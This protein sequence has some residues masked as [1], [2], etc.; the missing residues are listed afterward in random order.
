MLRLFPLI[1]ALLL[2]S[3]PVQAFETFEE[4]VKP[5]EASEKNMEACFASG[6]YFASLT[7]LLIYC[8][9]R[10]AG[11]ITEKT[12]TEVTRD[13]A[14]SITEEIEKRAWNQAVKELP[15]S[16]PNCPIKPIP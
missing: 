16:Y 12:F 4:I 15:D 11:D 1:G 8:R 10:E 2:S 3:T 9:Q 6:V 7:A 14:G 5:C 13:L